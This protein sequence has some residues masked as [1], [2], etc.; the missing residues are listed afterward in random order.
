MVKLKE[1]L[2][3][4]KLEYIDIY[5]VHGH[6]HPQSI[7]VVARSLA[8]CV[9]QGLTKTVAVANYDEGDMIKMK[10]ELA[11]YGVPLAAN[12][13]EYSLL[14]R[15]P[16]TSGL[17][18][19]CKQNDIVYQSYSSLA[20]GRLSGKYNSSNE[21]PKEYRFS[22]Y[23]MKYIEPTLDVQKRIAEKR[24]VSI[25]AV[26]LNYNLIHGIVPVVGMR[27]PEQAE[28]NCQA[29]GWRLSDDEIAELDS[30]SFEG[31][32]TALWQQG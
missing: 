32:T 3:K 28:T 30:V 12:Q 26:A 4:M 15:I 11:R 24:G 27:K 8:E 22:S 17:L 5:M 14:R 21:P 10:E 2:E 6:I 20:Q 25:A 16:E 19:A 1:S 7:A 9:D 29:L 13:C 31:K 23:P 18:Q